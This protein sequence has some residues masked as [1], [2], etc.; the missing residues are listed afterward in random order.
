MLLEQLEKP[1]PARY[2][3]ARAALGHGQSA[4][5]VGQH[6]T[7]AQCPSSQPPSD[8]SRSERVP[9]TDR[10]DDGDGKASNIVDLL[11]RRYQAT[12]ASEFQNDDRGTECKERLGEL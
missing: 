3:G 11:G 4:H 1:V 6:G 7:V 10:V 9:G 12:L 2:T 8:E 5:S